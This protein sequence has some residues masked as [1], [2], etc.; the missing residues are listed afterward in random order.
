M[1]KKHVGAVDMLLLV[2]FKTFEDPSSGGWS[3]ST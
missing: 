3:A 1:G 2:P